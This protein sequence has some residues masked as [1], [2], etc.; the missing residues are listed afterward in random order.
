MD[1]DMM[2]L[3]VRKQNLLCGAL[4]FTVIFQK[5]VCLNT[6][7]IFLVFF[8]NNMQTFELW[9]NLLNPQSDQNLISPN[10]DTSESFIKVIRIKGSDHQFKLLSLIVNWI[11][12]ISTEENV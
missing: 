5:F 4:S 6:F 10:S 12:L 7:N 8:C 1:Q 11:L 3:W 2:K 9:I